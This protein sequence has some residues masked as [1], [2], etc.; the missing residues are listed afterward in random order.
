[1]TFVTER[2]IA[3]VSTAALTAYDIVSVATCALLLYLVAGRSK[4]RLTGD[5]FGIV[6]AVATMAG[7]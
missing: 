4:A 3:L 5:L 6:L 1:M 2:P 7:S